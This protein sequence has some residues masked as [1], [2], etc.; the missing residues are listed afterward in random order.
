VSTYL[1]YNK[2]E[3]VQPTANDGAVATWGEDPTAQ[4]RQKDPAGG[5]GREIRSVRQAA[6]HLHRGLLPGALDQHRPGRPDQYAGPYQGGEFELNYQPDPHFFATA[7]YS[8]LHTTLEAPSPFYNFPAQPGLNNDGAGISAFPA[9]LNFAP[10]QTF[11]DP[12]VPQQLFNVL[13]NYK[14]ESGWGGQANIQVTS[15]ISVTQSGYLDVANIRLRGRPFTLS[16]A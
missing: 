9:N 5:R 7:S 8:Y 4:L 6:V 1:T 16:Q 10:G 15:P 3:Y 11:Q 2:A 13:A 14:H 12:G